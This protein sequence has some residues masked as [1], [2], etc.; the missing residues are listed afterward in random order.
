M[1][2]AMFKFL[3]ANSFFSRYQSS[4]AQKE[5]LNIKIDQRINDAGYLR[6][7]RTI[8]RIKKSEKIELKVCLI[9]F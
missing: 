9:F 7:I 1:R 5:T 3:D 4:N 8:L 2:W 6:H